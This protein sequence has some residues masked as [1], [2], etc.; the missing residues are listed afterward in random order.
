MSRGWR[1]QTGE[2]LILNVRVL[3]RASRDEV[4]GI[5]ADRLKI[6]IT[7]PP[8]DGSANAHLT[9]FLAREFGVAKSQVEIVSGQTGQ[10]KRIAIHGPVKQ[11]G[12]LAAD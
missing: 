4:V 7:A 1:Q 12:W 10:E 9:R 5:Q 8:V 6:R 2:T 11:P 3:P